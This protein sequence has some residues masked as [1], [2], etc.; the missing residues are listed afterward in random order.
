M[1]SNDRFPKL[2]Q[3]SVRS[4][5]QILDFWGRNPKIMQKISLNETKSDSDFIGN[6]VKW[7]D[8]NCWFK[9]GK[10]SQNIEFIVF[11][12]K[13]VHFYRSL[14][15]ILENWTIFG[16]ILFFDFFINKKHFLKLRSRHL[17]FGFC[18]IFKSTSIEL[19]QYFH[20]KINRAYFLFRMILRNRIPH[21]Q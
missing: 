17:L 5:I 11:S 1:P 21:P 15:S 18:W 19:Q 12:A 8:I 20:Q 13:F 9:M 3:Q 6:A 16:K 2:S 14:F 7:S 10:I 4:M